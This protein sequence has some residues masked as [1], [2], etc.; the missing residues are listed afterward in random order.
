MYTFTNEIKSQEA[1]SCQYKHLLNSPI[2]GKSPEIVKEV[3]KL[4]W[5]IFPHST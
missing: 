2:K 5:F 4:R 3:K 1:K